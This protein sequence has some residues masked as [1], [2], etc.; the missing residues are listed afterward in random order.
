[1]KKGNIRSQISKFY[2]IAKKK[3][4]IYIHHNCEQHERV[5]KIS[6]FHIFEYCQILAKYSY[7]WLLPLEQISPNWKNLKGLA[8]GF[9]WPCGQ[10]LPLITNPQLGSSRFDMVNWLQ[11][12]HM[13]YLPL[14]VGNLVPLDIWQVHTT[15]MCMHTY[16]IWIF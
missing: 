10:M 14:G 4:Y 5:L 9:N 12:N 16:V 13:G 11:E 15:C 8:W 3:Y 2:R 7:E 1:M 6:C